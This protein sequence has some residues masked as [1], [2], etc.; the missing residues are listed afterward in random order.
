VLT[1]DHALPQYISVDAA[2]DLIEASVQLLHALGVAPD[3]GAGGLD[4][5]PVGAQILDAVTGDD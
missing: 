4:E 1:L 2:E 5:W 3:N